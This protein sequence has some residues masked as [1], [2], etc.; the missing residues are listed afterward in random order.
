[1]GVKWNISVQPTRRQPYVEDVDDVS[2][3]PIVEVKFV[4]Y[5]C[6]YPPYRQ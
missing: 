1:M 6:K 4:E 3:P 2:S 5:R